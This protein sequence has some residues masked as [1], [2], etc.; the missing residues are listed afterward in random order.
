[1]LSAFVDT[2]Q[3]ILNLNSI[4]V[5]NENNNNNNNNNDNNNNNNNNNMNMN[6]GRE[7]PGTSNTSSF[8]AVFRA[9]RVRTEDVKIYLKDSFNHTCYIYISFRFGAWNE[10]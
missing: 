1:M 9:L 2:T 3:T 8:L 10:P 4:N 5:N 7:L 6:T